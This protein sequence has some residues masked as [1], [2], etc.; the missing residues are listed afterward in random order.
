[1]YGVY[2]CPSLK[3]EMQQQAPMQT[4]PSTYNEIDETEYDIKVMEVK[5]GDEVLHHPKVL[6]KDSEYQI[7]FRTAPM[8]ALYGTHGVDGDESGDKVKFNKPI[9]Q[10]VVTYTLK[11]GCAFKKVLKTM[12][13]LL[14]DQQTT[15][16]ILK[17]QHVELLT[18][19]FKD[20]RV[21]C[22]G[23][24]KARKKAA[25]ILKKNGVKKPT[26]E[27]IDAEAF[28]IYLANAHDSGVREKTWTENGEEVDGEVLTVRRKVRGVRYVNEED[29][30]GKTVRKRTLVS[31]FPIFHRGTPTG[32]FFEKKFGDYMPRDTLIILRVR[33]SFYTTPMMYG[34]N[35]TFDKDVI[36][37]CG[38]KRKAK[39]TVSKPVIYFEDEDVQESN[40]RKRDDDESDDAPSPKR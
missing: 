24:D 29:E 32:E 37:L 12:P 36:V 19:A 7:Y 31:T 18:A 38:P 25:G 13:N 17:K 6:A 21:K 1:M 4:F 20:K 16:D 10:A 27:Q 35:I 5:R 8:S 39:Q 15:F 34:S 22:G 9:E 23:K 28:N 14:K 33:R 26:P 40:K 11:K 2:A 30:S 3:Q